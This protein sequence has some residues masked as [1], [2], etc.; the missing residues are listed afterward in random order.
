M[1][2]LVLLA[3]YQ[4]VTDAQTERLTEL[5]YQYRALRCFAMPTRDKNKCSI[6]FGKIT[7]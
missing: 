4:S 5:L 1:I 2:G 3:L 6:Y 7:T